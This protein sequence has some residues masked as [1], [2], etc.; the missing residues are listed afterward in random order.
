MASHLTNLG[1][2]AAAG[3]SKMHTSYGDWCP[4]PRTI[5]GG[6]G[7]QPVRPSSAA[8]LINAVQQTAAMAHAA[9]NTSSSTSYGTLA[10]RLVSEYNAAFYK[11]HGMYDTGT[12]TALALNL[13]IGAA[14]ADINATRATLLK[15]IAA[16]ET[17]ATVGIIGSCR[18]Y[19]MLDAARAHDTALSI[20]T[21]RLPVVW[22]RVCNTL[23]KTTTNLWELPDAVAEGTGMNSRNHHMYSS[24]SAYLVQSVANLS[25]AQ[26]QRRV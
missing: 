18:L 24:F 15:A 14:S 1:K 4:P 22:L 17:H 5:G 2:Q 26:G 23:E 11:G 9:G 7:T 13:D 21:D 25:Q 10:K 3:L 20:L 12:Q 8:S 6:Q 16:N 19:Q